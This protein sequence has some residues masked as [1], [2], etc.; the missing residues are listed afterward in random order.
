MKTY[1]PSAGEADTD[2]EDSLHPISHGLLIPL[3]SCLIAINKRQKTT[4]LRG[5]NITIQDCGSVLPKT[6]YITWGSLLNMWLNSLFFMWGYN[7]QHRVVVKYKLQQVCMPFNTVSKTSGPQY[8][9]H[10]TDF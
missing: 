8:M 2:C 6:A 5:S 7:K 1:A 10:Y 3:F 9:D 4:Q